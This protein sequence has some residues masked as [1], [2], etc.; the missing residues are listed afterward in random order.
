M[1]DTYTSSVHKTLGVPELLQAI[2]VLSDTEDYRSHGLVCKQWSEHILNFLWHTIGTRKLFR[3]IEAPSVDRPL[4]PEDGARFYHYASRIL[5][6][7]HSHTYHMS[8][9]ELKF[10]RALEEKLPNPVLPNLVDLNCPVDPAVMCLF[11]HPNVTRLT[12]TQPLSI[13]GIF[14]R[15]WNDSEALY[16]EIT[17]G[18]FSR[19]PQAMPDLTYLK[20]H[21]GINHDFQHPYDEVV[22]PA[23]AH[24]KHLK[25]LFLPAEWY[26]DDITRVL[27]TLPKLKEIGYTCPQ[28]SPDRYWL[29]SPLSLELRPHSF[30]SIYGLDL[31]VSFERATAVFSTK[32]I[33]ENLSS[34]R[35]TQPH[36][37]S[38][39]DLNKELRTPPAMFQSLVEATVNAFPHLRTLGLVVCWH[40][41]QTEV[42]Y[43]NLDFKENLGQ[44]LRLKQLATLLIL[45]ATPIDMDQHDLEC[46][47]TSLPKLQTL[48]LNPT[49]PIRYPTTLHLTHLSALTSSSSPSLRSRLDCLE[50]YVN[51]SSKDFPRDQEFYESIEPLE[52]LRHLSFGNSILHSQRAVKSS[53]AFISWILPDGFVRERLVVANTPDQED[54]FLVRDQLEL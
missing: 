10:L 19:I 5:K 16:L 54:W 22:S 34:L 4:R 39:Q 1:M 18:C 44:L 26:T 37:S 51:T 15:I 40:E 13:S 6:Y 27:S 23:L 53:A 29:T 2:L 31:L 45:Y 48:I 41:T 49:P 50:V 21:F 20:V 46:I 35:V 3:L 47:V 11:A 9:F 42:D 43:P 36:S 7:D 24:L 8:R 33:N 52:D 12:L 28:S 14:S 32:S 25:H 17:Q 38:L 30:A